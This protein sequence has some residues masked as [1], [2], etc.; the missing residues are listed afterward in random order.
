MLFLDFLVVPFPTKVL[1]QT[2]SK[3]IF[4]PL[5]KVLLTAKIL[6]S[7]PSITDYYLQLSFEPKTP[8]QYINDPLK[9]ASPH[10]WST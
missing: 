1:S 2:E 10:L 5:V 3:L 7:S 6:T 4:D 8:G 9:I